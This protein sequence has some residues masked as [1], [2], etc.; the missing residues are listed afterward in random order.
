MTK[1][2]ATRVQ[3]RRNPRLASDQRLVHKLIKST[4][5]EMAGCFYEWQATQRR[6]GDDFYE[7]YPSVESFIRQDWPNFVKTAKECLVKQLADPMVSEIEKQDIYEAL[8]NDAKLPY[9]QQEVQI[10]NFRH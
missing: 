1:S 7:K 6:Y 8:L 5:Q 9:S 2:S 4:A 3:R 10:T